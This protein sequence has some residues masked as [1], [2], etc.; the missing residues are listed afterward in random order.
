V[1]NAN[2]FVDV[3]LTLVDSTGKMLEGARES[4]K[5]LKAEGCHLF[6][7]STGG[8][9]YCRKIASLHGLNELFEGF[10]AKP[11]IIIDDMPSTCTTAFIYNVQ[12]EQSW[13]A[14]AERI[15]EK[16]ID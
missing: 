5:R 1:K 6:L 13:P 15:I 9:E 12:H 16:H 8:A 10:T 14:L 7:W 3:D 2:V 11:D 4:L